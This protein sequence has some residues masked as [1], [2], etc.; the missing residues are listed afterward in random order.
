MLQITVWLWLKVFDVVREQLVRALQVQP[1]L[2][3]QFRTK[4]SQLSYQQITTIW[5]KERAEKEDYELMATPIQLVNRCSTVIMLVWHCIRKYVQ[6]PK[7]TII[8]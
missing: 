3:E 7:E 8:W 4:L 5:Q 6:V 2:F 1:L